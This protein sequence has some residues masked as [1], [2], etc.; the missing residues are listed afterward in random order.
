MSAKHPAR[1]FF[2][3]PRHV[4][5]GRQFVKDARKLL[6]YKRDIWSAEAVSDVEKH[7]GK[8][9]DAIQTK[10]KVQITETAHQLDALLGKYLPVQQDAWLR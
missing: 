2:L 3:T 7:I 10:D 6:A 1:M 5:Q 8:L 4:K 9:E